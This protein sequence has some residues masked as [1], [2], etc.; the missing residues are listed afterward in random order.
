MELGQSHVAVVITPS[1]TVRAL[2]EMVLEQEGFKATF[3]ATPHEALQ[4]LRE[5]VPS[6]LI[7]DEGLEPD[8]F[9]V[10]GRLKMSRRL[11]E[12]PILIL[13]SEHDDRTR[14]TA[15]LSRVDHVIPKPFESRQLRSLLRSLLRSNTTQEATSG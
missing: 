2:L 5:S 11:R 1:P 10:S 14:I 8:A 7:L 13:V 9:S 6:V 3:F 12:M 4:L 15:E